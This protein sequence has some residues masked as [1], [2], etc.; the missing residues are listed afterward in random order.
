MLPRPISLVRPVI[1]TTVQRFQLESP[2]I[3][4]TRPFPIPVLFLFPPRSV[5]Q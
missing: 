2:V 4:Q 5:V 3:V 1:P